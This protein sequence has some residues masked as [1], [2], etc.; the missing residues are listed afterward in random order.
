VKEG[1]ASVTAGFVAALRGLTPLLPRE[2]QLVDD[3]YGV[4]FGPKTLATLRE[5][6][7]RHPALSAGLAG[8]LLAPLLGGALNL[9]VRTRAFDDLVLDFLRASGRQLVILGAG[10]D[11]RAL[12]LRLPLEGCL[13][14]EIDHPATQA[15][16][17][18][19]LSRGGA[20]P[21][22]ARYVAFDF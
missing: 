14:L 4:L 5:T 1:S 12:R 6:S 11:C 17:R 16:K 10:F 9:Q 18:R 21:S 19:V 13:V 3:P 8:P 20:P 15:A 22:P 7:L 2:A